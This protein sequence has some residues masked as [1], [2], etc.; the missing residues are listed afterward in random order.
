MPEAV[1]SIQSSVAYGHVGNASAGFILQRMGFDILRLDTVVFSNH[2]GRGRFRGTVTEDR[3]LRE[4]LLGLDEQALLRRA[5]AVLSGYLGTAANGRVVLEALSLVRGEHGGALYCCDPV[6]GDRPKGLYVHRD[7]PAFVQEKL[8]HAADIVTPNVFELELL[9]GL[10][11]TDRASAIGAA[12]SM[13]G[14]G[15]AIVLVTG[16]PTEAG[17]ETMALD[18]EG[19]WVVRT[20]SL[21]LPTSG[22]GDALTALFLA[23]YLE[24]ADLPRALSLAVSALHHVLERTCALKADELHLVDCQDLLPNPGRV[25]SPEPA[26]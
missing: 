21:V 11:V 26:G 5:G 4:L 2:P 19:A 24:K 1:L 12:R 23:R 17:M 13:L 20:P 7:I 22:A 14:R 3:H 10:P 8:L 16:L 15:P 25:F 6:L 9:S 18:A